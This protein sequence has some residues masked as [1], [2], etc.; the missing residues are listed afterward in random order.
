M[1]HLPINLA[2]AST[3]HFLV[4][5]ICAC[6]LFMMADILLDAPAGLAILTYNIVAFM[7]QPLTG[8][9]ADSQRPR[10][11]SLLTAAVAFLTIAVLLAVATV[12]TAV[13]MPPEWLPA[14]CFTTVAVVIGIGNSL[15]HV[16]GGKQTAVETH[17]DIRSL[18]VFV[19]TGGMGL[20]VG[21]LFHTWWLLGTLLTLLCITAIAQLHRNAATAATT[22]RT[23]SPSLSP[24]HSPDPLPSSPS[25]ASHASSGSSASPASTTSFSPLL[26]LSTPP[27]HGGSISPAT[28]LTPAPPWRMSPAMLT[29]AIAAIMA[30][31]LLRA[32]YGETF[33]HGFQKDTALSLAIASVATLGKAGGGWLARRLGL[34]AMAILLATGIAACAVMRE[35]HTAAMLAGIFLINTTMPVTLWM[36][37]RLLPGR[38]G[39]AFGLLAAVLVPGYLLAVT[40]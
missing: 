15:F 19:A 10:C 21:V 24:L 23:S 30:V 25:P 37:N 31:V 27:Y 33:T 12:A 7:T 5:G 17:N 2:L 6:C 16:W 11:D 35:S 28:Q 3:M 36:A 9:L 1:R 26:P 20:V 40:L 34:A 18:G 38:E 29:L 14:V 8:W 32:Y 13:E 22:S 39:L 4:D